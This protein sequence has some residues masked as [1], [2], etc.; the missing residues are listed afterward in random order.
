MEKIIVISVL[1]TVILFFLAA[2]YFFVKAAYHFVL[3]LQN[4]K[5]KVHDVAINI[6]PFLF[7]F[8]PSYY[9]SEGEKHLSLFKKSLF[10]SALACL[11]IFASFTVMEVIG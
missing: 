5:P 3:M 7:T 9:T 4:V 6:A 11:I 2:F 8:S 10:Y 1:I